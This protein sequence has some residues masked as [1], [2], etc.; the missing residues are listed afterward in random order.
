MP[1]DFDTREGIMREWDKWR[2]YITSG[3][4]ASWPRDAFESLLDYFDER[5]TE[6]YNTFS[7]AQ[8]LLEEC[9]T[10]G[11]AGEEHLYAWFLDEIESIEQAI[12]ELKY[13]EE[14]V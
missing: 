11:K 8:A 14:K 7:N 5:F 3:G 9:I 4:K 13:I 10:N 1:V 12:D 2:S 6:M